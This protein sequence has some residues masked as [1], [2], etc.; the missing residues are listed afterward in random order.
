LPKP[1]NRT[2]NVEKLQAHVQNTIEN[3]EEAEDYLDEHGAEI[4]ATEQNYLKQKNENRRE[5]IASL[6][7]EIKD[8]AADQQK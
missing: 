5:S 7:N 4:N 8:E 3:L 2:D 6:R 1:D